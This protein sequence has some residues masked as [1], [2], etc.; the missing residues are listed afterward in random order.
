M[1]RKNWYWDLGLPFEK[2]RDILTDEQNPRFPRVAARLLARVDEPEQVFSL[3]TPLAFCRRFIA[4]QQ[5]VNKDEWTKEKGAFWRATYERYLREFQ[6]S[7]VR[8]RQRQPRE[9]DSVTEELTTKLRESREALHLSQGEVADMLGCSQQFVSGIEQ[10]RE[11]VTIDYLRRFADKTGSEFDLVLR[12]PRQAH[13]EDAKVA[14]DY[15]ELKAWVEQERREALGVATTNKLDKGVMEVVAYA[16]DAIVN[17]RQNAWGAAIGQAPEKT[18]QFRQDELRRAMEQSQVHSFGWPVGV[19]LDRPE[20]EP[21]PRQDGIRASILV[22]DR[23][24]FDYWTLRT[25]LVFYLLKT[26]FEDLRSKGKIF[27]DTRIIRTAE[28]FMRIS[29]LYRTLNVGSEQK[30]VIRIRYTGL[31]GRVLSAGDP[32]RAMTMRT[33][34]VCIED[35]AETWIKERLKDI[36]PKLVDLVH[37]AVS[38]LC[39]LFDF[40]QP[41]KERVVQPLVEQ[42]VRENAG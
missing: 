41:S 20:F 26:L 39:M 4:I 14:E 35:E 17:A 23:S 31:R 2:I 22:P 8:L 32:G 37:T 10:G 28:T 42:F 29:R 36:E 1:K 11:K 9:R 16:P 5:E 6:H 30:I 15:T 33:Q 40:F 3:I 21:K 19:V 7:G 27:V 18:L 12:T 25:D 38:E 24:T 34:R 13:T